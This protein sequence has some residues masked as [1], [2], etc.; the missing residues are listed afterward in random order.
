M[1][2]TDADKLMIMEQ[3]IRFLRNGLSEN[4]PAHETY[5]YVP[6]VNEEIMPWE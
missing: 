4:R 2:R 6:I 3:L 1:D 5:E